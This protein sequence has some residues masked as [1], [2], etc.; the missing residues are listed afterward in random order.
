MGTLNRSRLIWTTK[1]EEQLRELYIS[2]LSLYQIAKKLG[3]SQSS[4]YFRATQNLKLRRPHKVP[5]MQK[6]VKVKD[7]GFTDCIPNPFSPIMKF[8]FNTDFYRV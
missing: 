5:R 4:V 6:V 7:R 8:N 2:G 1:E 3:R